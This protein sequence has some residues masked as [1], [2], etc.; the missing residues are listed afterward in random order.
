MADN[1]K[2]KGIDTTK[3]YVDLEGKL[4]IGQNSAALTR[5]P[6]S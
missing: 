1:T 3:T 6:V 4:Y 5:L 2:M